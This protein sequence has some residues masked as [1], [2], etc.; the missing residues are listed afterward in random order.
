MKCT[1][2]HRKA[3]QFIC[4]TCQTEMRNLL[5]GLVQGQQ[6]AGQHIEPGYLQYLEDAALG[7]TRLGVSVRRSS[8]FSRPSPCPLTNDPN[9]SFKGSPSELLGD[10]H[11]LLSGIVNQLCTAKN[12]LPPFRSTK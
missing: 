8:E 3:Q 6:L 12:A 10:S 4:G 1:H 7:Q 5:D 9:D 2:C 11:T